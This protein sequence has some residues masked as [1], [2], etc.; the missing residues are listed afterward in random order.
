MRFAADTHP[1][2]YLIQS[3]GSGS[4]RIG[5]IVHRTAIILSATTLLPV[6]QVQRAAELTM[7]ELDALLETNPQVVLVGSP[8]AD[9]WPSQ[10]WRARLLQQNVGVEVM[11]TGAACRTYN[12]LMS[13]RRLVSALL[14]P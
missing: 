6:P 9:D 7:S 14:I 3:Y 1:E 2:G 8:H 13:E 5:Q 4:L 10:P 11:N 12:V